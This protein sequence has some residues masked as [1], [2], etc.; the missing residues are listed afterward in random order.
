M[1][2]MRPKIKVASVIN[3]KYLA[4]RRLGEGGC[5]VIYEVAMLK[6]P[7][8]RFACKAET[9]VPDEDPTLPMEHK[10]ISLLNEKNSIHCV[11]L[12][13][14]GQAENYQFIVMTLLGPS[15]DAIRAAIPT[16][17]FSTF[18][19]LVIVIQAL[20][21]LK[22]IHEIGYVHRDVKPANFAI[23][24]LGTP[25]Q[26]LVHVLDFG[27][28]RQF[29]V[30]D[31]EGTGLR[32]RKP[33]RIVPF[34]GT[35]RYCSVAAQDRK[36]QGRHDDL[37][38]LFYMIVEFVKGSLPWAGIS[39]EEKVIVM[40]GDVT[41]LF[42]GLEQE[43]VSFAQHLSV[44][45]YKSKPDYC[46]LRDLL[47]NVFIRKCFNPQ[48]KVDWEK[49]GR[50]EI[51]FEKKTATL[52]TVTEKDMTEVDLAK[53][54]MVPE[55]E[56]NISAEEVVAAGKMADDDGELNTAQDD[57]IIEGKVATTES[58][59]K[60]V[61]TEASKRAKRRYIPKTA[62]AHKVEV[63]ESNWRRKDEAAMKEK[64]KKHAM[65]EKRAKADFIVPEEGTVVKRKERDVAVTPTTTPSNK[66][67]TK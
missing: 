21:T 52:P 39:D 57:T 35:L 1:A 12:I 27:I 44:L 55:T 25:K 31:E 8:R 37:W 15:L 49:G 50:Y 66:R 65:A 3:K 32:I 7:G 20:D 17:K 9:T 67:K 62:S 6:C 40:K 53:L 2:M 34:R 26:R 5:G 64:L 10:V 30:A 22:E 14:K 58:K 48:M 33:R 16:H 18:S 54:L 29:L 28:A 4:F 24:S 11:E 43:F 19:T 59:P 60:V 61:V 45:R 38:S 56:R 41:E 42:N 13:E 51:H 63:I 36:E 47:L 23:G 46:L